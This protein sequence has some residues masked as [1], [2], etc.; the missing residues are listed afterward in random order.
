[1]YLEHY[2]VEKLKTEI[3]TV[4]GK[5]IDLTKYVVFFFGSRVTG[6]SNDRSDID[7]GIEGST[8]I[9]YGTVGKIVEEID[10]L[11]TLY[12]I[13]IVDFKKVSENFRK[14]AL[15]YTEKLV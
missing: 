11:P 3:L 4:I 2:S 12:K 5:Y 1:M 8:Q 6:K 7:L 13:E 14:V 9:P 10:D 15:Q